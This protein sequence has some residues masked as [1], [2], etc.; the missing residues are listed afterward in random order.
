MTDWLTPS[1]AA[2]RVHVPLVTILRWIRGGRLPAH[3]TSTPRY[4]L[5]PDD[6]D[7]VAAEHRA[8]LT[9]LRDKITPG[10]GIGETQ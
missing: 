3:I 8:R 2:R 9:R 5:R 4:Q 6:V 7:V 10:E 1:Q